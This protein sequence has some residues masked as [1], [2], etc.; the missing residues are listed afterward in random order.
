MSLAVISRPVAFMLGLSAAARMG[1]EIVKGSYEL[2][3][4]LLASASQ[5]VSAV[6]PGAGLQ[7]VT[8]HCYLLGFAKA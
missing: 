4:Q 7:K 3:L 2:E 6:K 5:C 8:S 1:K